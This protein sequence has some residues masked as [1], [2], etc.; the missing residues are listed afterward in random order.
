[1]R[2]E[3]K[4]ATLRGVRISSRITFTY[5]SFINISG[6]YIFLGSQNRGLTVNKGSASWTCV[7]A[8][9]MNKL[10]NRSYGC[11]LHFRDCEDTLYKLRSGICHPRATTKRFASLFISP[12]PM[13]VH[14]ALP[15]LAANPALCCA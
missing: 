12:T 9:L 5:L 15:F 2:R 8:G 4:L 10:A 11:L 14:D 6:D 13:Y 7:G 3:E 1:M